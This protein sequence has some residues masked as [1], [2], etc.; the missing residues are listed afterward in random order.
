MYRF[1]PEP[2]RSHLIGECLQLIFK[3]SP[4]VYHA[5]GIEP[6]GMHIQIEDG[7]WEWPM[8]EPETDDP[9]MHRLATVWNHLSDDER[10]YVYERWEGIDEIAEEWTYH[11]HDGDDIIFIHEGLCDEAIRI[12]KGG[13][14]GE[15]VSLA[16]IRV[17]TLNHVCPEDT[18]KRDPDQ[19]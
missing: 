19:A 15:G 11:G 16:D 9:D 13:K 8:D 5:G 6:D 1:K 14:Y 17:M 7:N 4:D 2:R 12:T 3:L 18:E 10:R